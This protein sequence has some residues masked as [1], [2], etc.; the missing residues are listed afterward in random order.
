MPPAVTRFAA[1]VGRRVL[2]WFV[3]ALVIA[4]IRHIWRAHH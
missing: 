2:L 3:A 1:G 4:T